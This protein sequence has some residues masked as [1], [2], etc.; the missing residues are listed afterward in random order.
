MRLRTGHR[1]TLVT[2]TCLSLLGSLPS[3]AAPSVQAG[4]SPEGSAEQLVLKTIETAQH[5]IRLMGY[6]FTSPEVVRALISAKR[7]GV[8]VKVVLDEKGNRGKASVAAMNLLVNAGI[9]V[10]TVSKFKILHDKI[11]ISDKNT[12]ETGSYNFSLSAARSNSENALVIRDVPE[13]ART[14]LQHWQSRWDMGK[15]WRSTY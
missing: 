5:N 15:D 2:L 11:I 12:V 9:P 4:F 8:D 1:L 3:I 13:L 6:S 14:Y 7:R 10:R